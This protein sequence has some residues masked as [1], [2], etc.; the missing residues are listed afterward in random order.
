M[1]VFAMDY[2][3]TGQPAP[4]FRFAT[5]LNNLN[6]DVT[7]A[8]VDALV[9]SPYHFQS[10][11]PGCHLHGFP[12]LAAVKGHFDTAGR[13]DQVRFIALQMVFEGCDDNTEQAVRES[14]ERHGL[15]DIDA[16][17]RRIVTPNHHGRLPNR[18]HALVRPHWPRS[19]SAGRRL[20]DRC[21]SR[22]RIT[23]QRS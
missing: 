21:R 6:N 14:M 3:I 11:C 22:D 8:T 4:K 15:S 5:W 7:L 2:G 1:S 20:P 9:V 10:W 23:H 17:T 19:H 13:C 12:A 18:R 16:W